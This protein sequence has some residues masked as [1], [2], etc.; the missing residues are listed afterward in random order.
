MYLKICLSNGTDSKWVDLSKN[1]NLKNISEEMGSIYV[2]DI[3]TD[4][5]F[6]WIEFDELQNIINVF[7]YLSS[8]RL[9]SDFKK[10]LE[11]GLSFY[12]AYEKIIENRYYIFKADDIYD[13]GVYM[14]S[15]NHW[16]YKRNEIPDDIYK[17]LDFQ[18]IG[19]EFFNSWNCDFVDGKCI[20]VY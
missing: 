15:N 18:L 19:E 7:N 2:D 17:V 6:D 5:D 4:L 14:V 8:N 20:A 9:K 11:L 3:K 16:T 10:I 13:V 1:P 12:E